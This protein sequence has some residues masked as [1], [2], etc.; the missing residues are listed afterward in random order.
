MYKCINDNDFIA[1]A[2]DFAFVF[3]FCCET[4]EK[5]NNDFKLYNFDKITVPRLESL[6][7]KTKRGHGG[8]CLFYKPCLSRIF[9]VEKNDNHRFIW[10][11]VFNGK[12][13]LRFF[14]LYTS[15]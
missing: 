7:V 12:R 8:I 5:H 9:V 2:S 10:L 14:L 6:N 11:K 3:F 4:W 13:S 1:F 15:G